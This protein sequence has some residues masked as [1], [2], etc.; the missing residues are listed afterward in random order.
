MS[1]C[2]LCFSFTGNVADYAVT[3]GCDD[4]ELRVCRFCLEDLV[5]LGF[6]VNQTVRLAKPVQCRFARFWF[7]GPIRD[8][9]EASG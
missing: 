4:K 1:R 2:M 7:L 5:L 9:L 3:F 6:K 8:L